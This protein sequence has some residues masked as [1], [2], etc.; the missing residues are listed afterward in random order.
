[1][2]LFSPAARSITAAKMDLV[3]S[4]YGKPFIYSRQAM[5][6]RVR[7]C[8]WRKCEMPLGNEVGFSLP[9]RGGGNSVLGSF[10]SKW[11]V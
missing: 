8:T 5:R 3:H 11:G 9:I 1:M 10:C 2:V 6:P 7:C 4:V